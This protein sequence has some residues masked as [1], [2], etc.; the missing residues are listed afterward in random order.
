MMKFI[1]LFQVSGDTHNQRTFCFEAPLLCGIL[2][3]I[4]LITAKVPSENHTAGKFNF[5]RARPSLNCR[6]KVVAV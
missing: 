5:S 2:G 4:E 6:H 1:V 3:V